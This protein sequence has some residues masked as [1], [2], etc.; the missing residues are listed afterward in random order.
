[1]KSRFYGEA[2]RLRHGNVVRPGQSHE[3]GGIPRSQRLL[4]S[5]T[6]LVALLGLGALAALFTAPFADPV[7]TATDIRASAMPAP[8]AAGIDDRNRAASTRPLPAAPAPR[9]EPGRPSPGVAVATAAEPEAEVLPADDPRWAKAQAVVPAPVATPAI[10][11]SR[12]SG[13]PD[14]TQTAAIPDAEPIV[15][16]AKPETEEKPAERAG[17]SRVAPSGTAIVTSAVKMRARP[18]N[19]AGVVAVVPDNASVGLVGC[20]AWC[21]VVYKGRRGFIYKRFVD[22]SGAGTAQP[23]EAANEQ[24]KPKIN[25]PSRIDLNSVGR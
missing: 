11:P 1:M 25:K 18:A 24:R 4:L 13:S 3:D 14:D 2:A 20:Q 5:G 22:G 7:A 12:R 8:I 21:E 9:P 15:E 23:K 6:G 16:A 19:G 17:G 10:E